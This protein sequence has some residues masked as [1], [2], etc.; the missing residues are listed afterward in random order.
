M[1]TISLE[2]GD[3]LIL[4]TD[5]VIDTVGQ[6][7]RFGEARLG[8]ALASSTGAADAVERIDLAL[9]EFAQGPQG[10]DTAVLALERVATT[11]APDRAG[12]EP[13]EGAAPAG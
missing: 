9:R 6:G 3:Q 7:E 8:D 4:Y 10:D 12:A 5:G 11:A 13:I 1:E 2:P